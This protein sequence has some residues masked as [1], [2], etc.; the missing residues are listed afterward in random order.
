VY[1]FL[2]ISLKTVTLLCRPYN[3]SEYENSWGFQYC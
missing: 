3:D 1:A 2:A